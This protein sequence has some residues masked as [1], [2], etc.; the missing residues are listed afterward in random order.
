MKSRSI[1][2]LV[3]LLLCATTV[4]VLPAQ[5]LSVYPGDVTNNGIVNNIDFL[6]LGLGYNFVG[7]PRD[8]M[9]GNSLGFAPQSAQP[10]QFSL[11]N[12]ANMAYADCNGD[13]LVSYFYDAFPVYV[14]YGE[15][16]SDSTVVQD[17]FVHGVPGIDPALQLNESGLPASIH[18]G[19]SFSLP[20]DLGTAA[21]PVEDLYGI[22]FSIYVDPTY[23]DPATVNFNF[24]QTSWANPDNDRI[25]MHRKAGPDR[26]DVAW[27]RTDHNQRSGSGQIG[28]AEFIIIINVIDYQPFDI[29]VDNI[30]MLDKFG[31]ETV[32]AGDTIHV[33]MD[34]Q[35]LSTTHTNKDQS[36]FTVS[37]NPAKQ[38]LSIRHDL[39]IEQLTLRDAL[40]KPVL[41]FQP[42][43]SQVELPLP[44]LPAGFYWLEGR[45]K[46]GTFLRKIQIIP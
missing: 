35:V 8:S 14:N 25:F 28:T 34:E 21:L 16:R 23:I 3:F 18:A 20:I 2:R 39:P 32:V 42:N 37:P 27:V 38:F 44:V 33:D 13:G 7:P 36:R 29:R 6:Y 5:S 11:P 10:W 31:V 22:A 40:G 17:V 26:V 12:G 24:N 30:K 4:Q 19:V 9:Q 1:T 46:A 15:S 45:S 43:Q 41:Q